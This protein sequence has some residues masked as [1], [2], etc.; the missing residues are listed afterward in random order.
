M[1]FIIFNGLHISTMIK[2]NKWSVT[3]ELQGGSYKMEMETN[4]V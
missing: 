1:S 3:C 2:L 4:G